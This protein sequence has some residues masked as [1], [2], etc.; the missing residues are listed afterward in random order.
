MR[1]ISDEEWDEVF[2]AEEKQQEHAER[3]LFEQALVDNAPITNT[4]EPLTQASG[5]LENLERKLHKSISPEIDASL[6]LHLK[7]K[8]EAATA[9]FEFLRHAVEVGDR[10]ALV[11]TGKG[12]HSD[13][14]GVLRE[15]VRQWLKG[16]GREW[17]L[18]FAEA[19]RALGG[20]GAWLLRLKP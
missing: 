20:S 15:Y 19:P 6:D 14:K 10:T 18:W 16:D 9:L 4:I 2:L 3:K 1:Q 11:I 12:H 13:K 5:K 17:I 7:T 8:D